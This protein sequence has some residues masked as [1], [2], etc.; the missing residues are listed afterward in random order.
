MNRCII[1]LG[2]LKKIL[3]LLRHRAE[4]MDMVL[5]EFDEE[6]FRKGTEED[7]LIKAVRNL[8]KNMNLSEEEAIKALGI[9]ES[10]HQKYL[11]RLTS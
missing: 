6:V 3:D 8:M 5:T 11:D 9:P 2:K 10:E 7:I 4:V 1:R